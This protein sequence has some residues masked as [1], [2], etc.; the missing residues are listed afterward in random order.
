MNSAIFNREKKLDSLWV[1]VFWAIVFQVLLF[2]YL[3]AISGPFIYDD[4]DG[5]V[6][7]EDLRHLS[8]PWRLL[9]SHDS[10]LEFDR[11]PVTGLSMLLNF[12][13]AGLNPAGYRIINVLLHFLT[14]IALAGV[15]SR[16]ALRFQAKRGQWLSLGVAVL[17]LLHPL[18]TGAVSYIYQRSEVLMSLF[19]LLAVW[20]LLKAGKDGRRSWLWI[21]GACA[22]F[23][24]LSKEVGLTLIA[25]LPLVDRLVH[26]QSMKELI[27]SRKYYY[28]P[29]LLIFLGLTAWI[30]TGVR[31][32]ELDDGI[33]LITPHEYFAY[34][35]RVLM[36][37]LSL[38]LWPDPLI[39]NASSKPMVGMVS[40][41]PHLVALMVIFISTFA[42]GFKR[43]WL[44]L[45][46]GGFLFIL[47]PTSSV[48][49]IPL[50]PEAEFRMYLP[51]ALV[52]VAVLA[53]AGGWLLN[54]RYGSYLVGALYAVVL[55]ACILTTKTRNRVYADSEALWL[56]VV[57]HDPGNAKAWM[58]LGLIAI[59][60]GEYGKAK[61]CVYNLRVLAKQRNSEGWH[62]TARHLHALIQ[63]ETGNP[64]HALAEFE[65]LQS[66]AVPIRSLNLDMAL[67]LARLGR[68]N[69]AWKYWQQSQI[70]LS[71]HNLTVL[72]AKVE[73]HLAEGRPDLAAPVLEYL[74]KTAKGAPRV[75]R[76]RQ[77]WNEAL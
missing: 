40:W 20:S 34:Q 72:S 73:L 55:V 64:G 62:N 5:I 30:A 35:F 77:Q 21:S 49:P 17:W 48:I 9:A 12:K 32:G 36:R 58:D 6:D 27:N 52:L 63:L 41:L 57:Q 50:E 69:E 59:T 45:V 3:P 53:I 44:W 24:V 70:H 2:A 29:L 7:N 8:E 22:V 15:V 28:V 14:G 60:E 31:M 42:L 10:S 26:F 1:L 25:A 46:L 33:A 56:S 65:A 38:V 13:I 43:R 61:R 66:E 68:V 39:F 4:I 16:I 54:H 51:S 19:F 67:A 11:R 75:A 71:P 18:N 37:Y 47:A 76:L 23:S 74:E